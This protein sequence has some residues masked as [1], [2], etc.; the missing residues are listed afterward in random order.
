[1]IANIPWWAGICMLIIATF[2]YFEFF[3][4]GEI[5]DDDPHAM[6]GL[7]LYARAA[8]YLGSVVILALYAQQVTPAW[9]I[10]ALLGTAAVVAAGSVF[11]LGIGLKEYFADPLGANDLEEGEEA[12]GALFTALGHLVANSV[13]F[14]GLA[15]AVLISMKLLP[16]L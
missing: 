3:A 4:T 9:A 11:Y 14:I 13:N 10:Y 1:M 5:E 15:A 2:A 8:M 7:P 6:S 16:A 12:A